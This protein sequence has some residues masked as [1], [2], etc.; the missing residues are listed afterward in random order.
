MQRRHFST[1][2]D[3]RRQHL[4]AFWYGFG[5]L[6]EFAN[7]M[8]DVDLDGYRRYCAR[9]SDAAAVRCGDLAVLMDS[10]QLAVYCDELGKVRDAARAFRSE[11]S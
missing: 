5:K 2:G 4:D 3:E 10:T 8:I 6:M 7:G 1:F 9:L 11:V